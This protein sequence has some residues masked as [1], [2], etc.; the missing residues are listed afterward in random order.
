[1]TRSP[2]ILLITIDSLRPDHLGCYGYG[3]P[4]SPWIDRISR[5]GALFENAVSQGGWTS[6]AM[7]SILTGLYPSVHGV[8]GR[9]DMFP[10]LHQAPLSSWLD[11]GYRVPG[12]ATINDEGNYARLGFQPDP[13]YGYTPD[14]LFAWIRKYRSQPF[15]CW[16]HINKTP[17]LPYRPDEAHHNMFQ[18]PG[19]VSLTPEQQDRLEVV[20]S[21]VII[22]RGTLPLTA[23]DLPG[24][25]ALYDGEVRMADDTVGR[26]YKFLQQEGLLDSTVVILTA[27]QAEELLDHGFIGHASTS[28]AGTVHEEIVHVPLLIRY[29]GAISPGKVVRPVVETLDI[30][31]TLQALRGVPSPIPYQGRSLLPLLQGETAEWIDIA[32]S[33]TSPCGYQ[34]A[35]VPEKSLNRDHAVRSGPWKLI[36][37]HTPDQ[38]RFALY[39]LESDPGEKVDQLKS[40]PKIAARLKDLLLRQEYKNRIRRKQLFQNCSTETEP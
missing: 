28:W 18:P 19:G 29:P 40:R 2:N 11:A 32:F 36:A 31:P 37:S 23:D 33:E 17:H 12:Y 35:R 27:D 4:T 38:T 8:E 34:C 7:V 39:N 24:I 21:K 5:E 15:F 25:L 6:P 3:K 30:L 22:P 10:C 16:Y 20:R 13:E 14:Q 1:L 26:I 9:H